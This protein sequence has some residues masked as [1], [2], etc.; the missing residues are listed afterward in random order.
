[1]LELNKSVLNIS[2]H[3]K[4]K[5]IR[6]AYIILFMIISY[7]VWYLIVFS[8]VFQFFYSLIFKRINENVANLSK[9]ASLYYM[10]IIQFITFNSDYKPFPISPF[11]K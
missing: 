3:L 1:M 9:S 8:S 7:L 11:P 2:P 5:L 10:E 6:G 4:D